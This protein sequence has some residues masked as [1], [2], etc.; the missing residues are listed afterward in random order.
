M[1]NPPGDTASCIYPLAFHSARAQ[2]GTE[3]Y[4]RDDAARTLLQ[5][6]QTKGLAAIKEEDRRELWYAD[7]I[8]FQAKE[9]LYAK[10]L[11]PAAFSTRGTFFDLLRYARFLEVFASC[12]PA[13]GY[14]LQVTFLGLFAVLMGT[15]EALK[16][17]AV[18]RLEAGELLAFAVSEQAHGSDLMANEF[19]FTPLPSPAGAAPGPRPLEAGGTKHYIG[20]SNVASIIATL[21]RM[22]AA[23]D[24]LLAARLGRVPFVLAALRPARGTAAWSEQKI[25]TLGVRAAHVG[26]FEVK[27]HLLTDADV[28]AQGRAAWDAVFGTVTLGKFFLGFGSIG[29]C[30]RA[31]AEASTHLCQRILYGKPAIE[32]EHLQHMMA[33]AYARLLAMKLY[34]YRT[35]DYVHAASAEDRRYQ[36]FCAVQKA[37]ISTEGVKVMELISQCIG[38]RGFEGDTFC[39]MALRDA[40]LIPGLEGSM[41]INLLLALQFL[42]RYF[43]RAAPVTTVPSVVGGE[44]ASRENPYLMTARTGATHSIRFHWFLQPYRAFR[45][46]PNVVLFARQ[47]ACFRRFVKALGGR[48]DR[49]DL[50]ASVA[51]GKCMAT[52]AYAQLIAENAARLALPEALVGCLFALQVNDMNHAAMELSA[53]G[54]MDERWTKKMIKVPRHSDTGWTQ[55][56]QAVRALGSQA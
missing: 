4:L 45:A 3:A 38:A 9:G 48:A 32:M 24:P 47:A 18:A 43:E 23:G 11:S 31:L 8:K 27:Q 44:V 36:L 55:V 37:K 10:V 15:N 34:A 54:V 50:R 1:A 13:H 14:S 17:E 12:S 28:I 35:L 53:T 46:Q 30:E 22:D 51:L 39:E 21:G 2:R 7:W 42:P 20:N 19:R 56:A 25:H 29:I 6:F 26:A 52:L 49:T 33:E 16:R 5:F 40:P 41:H